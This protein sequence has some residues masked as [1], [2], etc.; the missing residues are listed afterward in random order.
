MYYLAVTDHAAAG[1]PLATVAYHGL[2]VV[3]IAMYALILRDINTDL[4]GS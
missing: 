1:T 4:V 2:V 3:A